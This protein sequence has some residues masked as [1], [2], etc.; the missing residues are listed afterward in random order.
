MAIGGCGCRGPFHERVHQ[1][2]KEPSLHSI[3][4]EL[5]AIIPIIGV[6]AL[7]SLDGP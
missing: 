7:V 6:V 2:C 3:I 1:R 5:K 4:E